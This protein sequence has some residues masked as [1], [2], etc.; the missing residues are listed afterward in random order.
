LADCDLVWTP[1]LQA[2]LERLRGSR[3]PVA[4]RVRGR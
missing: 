3:R 2:L 4:A 1:D